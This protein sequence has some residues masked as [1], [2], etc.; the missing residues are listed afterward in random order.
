[1]S[2]KSRYAAPHLVTYGDVR[3]LTRHH[4]ADHDPQGKVSVGPDAFTQKSLDEELGS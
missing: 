1:M 4:R 3:K 2:E